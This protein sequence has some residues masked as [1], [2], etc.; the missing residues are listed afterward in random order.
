MCVVK[1]TVRDASVPIPTEKETYMVHNMHIKININNNIIYNESLSRCP[2]LD[3][4]G[5]TA[6]PRRVSFPARFLKL[7]AG[8]NKI[9]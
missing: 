2:C 5:C 4:H 3:V 1:G 6:C 8:G 9:K 7:D